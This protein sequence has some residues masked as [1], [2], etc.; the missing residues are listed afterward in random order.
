MWYFVSMRSHLTSWLYQ[1]AREDENYERYRF[2]R[3]VGVAYLGNKL[4]LRTR[5]RNL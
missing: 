3:L 1:Y 5:L 2:R 4:A